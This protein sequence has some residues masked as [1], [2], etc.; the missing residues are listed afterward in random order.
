MQRIPEWSVSLSTGN[1]SIDCLRQVLLVL[2][3]KTIQ[4]YDDA[5]LNNNC[6]H[7]SLNRLY[8]TVN[9]LFSIEEASLAARGDP[10]LPQH[11]AEHHRYLEQITEL[12]IMASVGKEIDRDGLCQILEDWATRHLFSTDMISKPYMTLNIRSKN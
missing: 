5:E 6:F 10:T 8:M 12:L 3:R 11:K 4:A 9:E 7:E 2:A 1:P